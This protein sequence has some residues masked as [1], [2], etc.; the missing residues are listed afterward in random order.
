[1][2]WLRFQKIDMSKFANLNAWLARCGERPV[3][4]KAMAAMMAAMQAHKG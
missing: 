1:M 4:K 3:Y 2:D